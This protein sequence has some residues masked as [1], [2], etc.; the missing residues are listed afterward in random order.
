[1]QITLNIDKA[2]AALGGNTGLYKKVLV[3]FNDSYRNAAS[4]ISEHLSAG[5][6]QDAERLAHTLKG[7]AGNI[8]AEELVQASLELE[9][10]IKS[11]NGKA[12]DL[13]TTFSEVLEYTLLAIQKQ[14]QA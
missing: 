5:E 9:M 6:L 1:M 11:N 8:G 14:L 13:L 7:L 3:R 4:V 2:V 10:A 12:P